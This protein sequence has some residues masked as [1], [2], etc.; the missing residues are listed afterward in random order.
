MNFIGE[1]LN[2]IGQNTL[3]I[4][5]IGLIFWFIFRNK[6]KIKNKIHSF[7]KKKEKIPSERNTIKLEDEQNEHEFK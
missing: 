4:I 1:I 5:I 2:F 6:E 7:K 3:G